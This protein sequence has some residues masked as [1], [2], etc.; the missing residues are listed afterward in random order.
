MTKSGGGT[1]TAGGPAANTFGGATLVAQGVYRAEKAT[2][3]GTAGGGVNVGYGAT[4]ALAGGITVPAEILTIAGTGEGGQAAVPL[5]SVGGTNTWAGPLTLNNLPVGMASNRQALEVSDGTLIVNGLIGHTNNAGFDKLGD[6]TLQIKGAATNTYNQTSILWQGTLESANT[7]G[8]AIPNVGL[9]IGDEVGG[10]DA[11]RL[12]LLASNQIDDALNV[13]LRGG[14]QFSLGTF[15]D[16]TGG[17][18][19]YIG[20]LGSSEI[21]TGTGTWRSLGSVTVN[22]YSGG[23]PAPAV[24]S[25]NV[26]LAASG[27]AS[28]TRTFTVA[29]TAAM[30]DLIVSA[31]V[32]D[33]DGN[34]NLQHLTKAGRGRMALT[35]ANMYAGTTTISGGELLVANNT[36]LGVGGTNEVQT[37]TVPTTVTTFTLTYNGLTAAA[38]TRATADGAAVRAALEPLLGVGNVTVTGAVAGPYTVTFTGQLGTADVSQLTSTVTSGSGTITHATTTAGGGH[39]I[40][41]SGNNDTAA[42]ASLLLSGGITVTNELLRLDSIN[43]E[44]N[45]GQGFLLQGA[46]R[47]LDGNNVWQGSVVLSADNTANYADVRVKV[48]QDRLTINGGITETGVTVIGMGLFKLGDGTLQLAGSTPNSVGQRGT[49]NSAVVRAAQGTIELN[50]TPGV[51]AVRGRVEAGDNNGGAG[52]DRIVWLA[53]DEYGDQLNLANAFLLAETT[54]LMDLNGFNE[55]V[56]GPGTNS[57]Y[58]RLGTLWSGTFEWNGGTM[59][60]GDG[61]NAVGHWGTGTLGSRPSISPPGLIRDTAGTGQVVLR[62]NNAAW[63]SVDSIAVVD[64]QVSARISNS[65]GGRILKTATGWLGLTADNNDTY[66]G[67]TTVI[68]AGAFTVAAGNALGN[69]AS[70]I[71]VTGAAALAGLP[72]GAPV[73]IPQ[74]IVLTSADLTIRGNADVTLSGIFNGVVGGDRRLISDVNNSAVVEISGTVNISNDANNRVLYL[75]DRTFNHATTVSGQIVNG[76]T[77][78]AGGV[79]KEGVGTIVLTNTTNSYAGVTTVQVGTLRRRN[80]ALPGNATGNTVV[81]AGAA[82]EVETTTGS[83]SYAEPLDLRS[84]GFNN[85]STGGLRLVDGAPGASQ[86]VTFTGNVVVGGTAAIGIEAGDANGDTLVLGGAGVL[87]G[88]NVL[89]KA[90]PG[91]LELAGT[92][93]NT[94]GL[95]VAPGLIVAQGTVRLNKNPGVNAVGSGWIQIG[96]HAGGNGA[97]RLVWAAHNQLPDAA[98]ITVGA[99]GQLDLGAASDAVGSLIL[100]RH[101]SQSGDVAIGS[102]GVLTLAGNTS[103]PATVQVTNFGWTDGATPPATLSGPGTLQLTEAAPT[104]VVADSLLPSANDDLSVSAVIGGTYSGTAIIGAPVVLQAHSLVRNAGAT[105]SFIGAGAHLDAALNAIKFDAVPAGAVGGILPYAT[106]GRDSNY[107]TVPETIDLVTDVDPGAGDA[108]GRLAGYDASNVKVTANTALSGT[109]NA[110][111]IAG[112]GITVDTSGGLT[113]PADKW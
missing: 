93:A 10:A 5:R 91:T 26:A 65:G 56:V 8:N 32:T 86:T 99:S 40:V 78:T 100:S 33:G 74:T 102:G 61:T 59:T 50:K 21:V 51:D 103:L 69:A 104:I 25:G 31:A 47:S 80:G 109:I 55:T 27:G 105:V 16:A 11:D 83:L 79:Q 9:T 76:G 62:T 108:V 107:D 60:L 46:L 98:L 101:G 29:S 67:A 64:T 94:N 4:V 28:A 95:A 52:V 53:S 43:N 88:V 75:E 92:A 2:A 97:D 85:I 49:G 73:N 3:F 39:T 70:A 18:T 110:L 13:V 37:V 72:G 87:S 89:S 6:G 7:A 90:G 34:A 14:A 38:I 36:A 30:P 112:D 58:T 63:D 24:I 66:T 45:N 71:S 48:D 57:L 77:S 35:S 113:I 111:L 54:G 106:V 20:P 12:V 19:L 22:A 96:D 68:S 15:S 17:A 82:L 42:N 41:N 44:A 84:I 1:L 81:V 23:A